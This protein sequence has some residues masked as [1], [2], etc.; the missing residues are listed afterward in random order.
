MLDG[1]VDSAQVVTPQT[2]PETKKDGSTVFKRVWVSLDTSNPNL[3]AME[4]D[5]EIPGF[6]D[7][8]G[9]MPSPPTDRTNKY[10]VCI[11]LN[12]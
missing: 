2:I 6:E 4:N 12:H 9:D 3:T 10:Q 7:E 1:D 8:P 11:N 5:A